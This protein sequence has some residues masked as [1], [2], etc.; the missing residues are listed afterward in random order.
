MFWLI[1]ERYKLGVF[2]SSFEIG[3]PIRAG[4]NFQQFNTNHCETIHI[5]LCSQFSSNYSIR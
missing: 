1:V 2:V 5:E 3:H 4:T